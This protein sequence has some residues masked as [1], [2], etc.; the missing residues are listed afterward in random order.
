MKTF[1][2]SLSAILLLGLTTA[3]VAQNPS[4]LDTPAIRQ[5]ERNMINS[6]VIDFWN[7]NHSFLAAT[8]MLHAPA[9]QR[10]LGITQ[11]QFQTIQDFRSTVGDMSSEMIDGKSRATSRDPD[12]QL[13]L[14]EQSKLGNPYAEDTSEEMRSTYFNL[15]LE[16][17]TI[18]HQKTTNVINETLT[19][20]QLKKAGEFHI[21]I[22]SE[23]ELISPNMFEVLGLSDEQKKQLGKVKENMDTEF[24]KQLD[25]M[26][27]V[28][29]KRDEKLRA[30]MDKV[31]DSLKDISPGSEE[32]RK[33]VDNVAKNVNTANPDLMRELE[34]AFASSKALGDKLKV[35]MFDVLTDEQW[36]RLLKLTDDP[37]EYAKNFLRNLKELNEKA[38][39]WQPGPNSWKPGDPIPE[40][41]R[42]QRQER[43]RFPRPAGQQ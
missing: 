16:M 9:F 10:E 1:R 20:E 2:L 4:R 25:R 8:G 13:L 19:P 12:I 21:A 34:A 35:E 37:S 17:A 42:Q 36:N 24:R 30:E 38:A 7:G 23:N 14:D 5:A 11:E 31:R 28:R 33:R 39:A 29:S 43:G 6:D 41:Y 18:R 26:S 22:M 27:E 3:A 15:E 40:G 32:W